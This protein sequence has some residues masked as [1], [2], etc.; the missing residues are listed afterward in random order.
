MRAVTDGLLF[1]MC[2]GGC[3]GCSQS[4]QSPRPVWT[5]SKAASDG[6]SAS[7]HTIFADLTV[8]GREGLALPVSSSGVQASGSKRSAQTV[9]TPA[10]S[11]RT[12]WTTAEANVLDLAPGE[13]PQSRRRLV[14]KQRVS[15]ASV[16]TAATC[17]SQSIEDVH[18]ADGSHSSFRVL[19]IFMSTMNLGRGGV[20]KIPAVITNLLDLP[21]EVVV[22][23][24]NSI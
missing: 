7:P 20:A 9:W 18:E 11:R 2:G 19:T 14:G 10:N 17:A 8:C 1:T 24:K 21:S 5:P 23:F 13:K 4:P 12:V 3:R 6:E 15:N 22:F 16:C